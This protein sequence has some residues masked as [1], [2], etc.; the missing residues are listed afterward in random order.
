MPSGGA[1]V[2]MSMANT[3]ISSTC[4]LLQVVGSSVGGLALGGPVGAIVGTT[5]GIASGLI[6]NS[7]Q[8]TEQTNTCEL[9]PPNPKDD[10]QK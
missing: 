9:P 5:V 3:L 8:P 7:Q 6:K 10:H 4:N 1:I 2:A